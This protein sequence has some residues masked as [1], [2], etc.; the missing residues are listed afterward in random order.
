MLMRLNIKKIHIHP[1]TLHNNTTI[2]DH[3]DLIHD[4]NNTSE[5]ENIIE[6]ETYK[7]FGVK[8]HE[9]EDSIPVETSQVFTVFNKAIHHEDD[10][11]DDKSVIEIE[12]PQENGEKENGKWKTGQTHYYHISN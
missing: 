4:E 5:N 1:E 9:T 12:P 2:H 8:I 3:D 11:S 6:I 10:S 7:H